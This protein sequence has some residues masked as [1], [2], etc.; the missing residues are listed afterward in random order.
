MFL[1]KLDFLSPNITL[2]HKG[3]LSHSSKISG[4]ISI[5]SLI[6]III[7]CIYYLIDLFKRENPKLYFL[8]VLLIRQKQFN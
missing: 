2:Y 8:I 4:I 1:K 3:N 7:F 5:I 6:V